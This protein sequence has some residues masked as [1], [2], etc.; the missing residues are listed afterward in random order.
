MMEAE[1]QQFHFSWPL[2]QLVSLVKG[3]VF[4]IFYLFILK[5]GSNS[6]FILALKG[7]FIAFLVFSVIKIF[8]ELDIQPL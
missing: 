7:L 1:R 4:V 3:S 6:A 8:F 2:F 5:A